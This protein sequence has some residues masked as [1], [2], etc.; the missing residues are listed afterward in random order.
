[1]EGVAFFSLLGSIA[2]LWVQY[3]L[4]QKQ[5]REDQADMEAYKQWLAKKAGENVEQRG[6]HCKAGRSCLGYNTGVT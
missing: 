2:V 5:K 1:M 3:W 4:F 6:Q